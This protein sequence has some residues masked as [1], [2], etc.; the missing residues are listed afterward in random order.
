MVAGVA[1]GM[2]TITASADG[3]SGSATITVLDGGIVSSNGGT[4]NVQS[5]AVQIEVPPDALTA[6]TNLSVAVSNAFGSDPRVVPNSAFDFGPPGTNFAK[7]VLL[8]IRYD[9][10]TLPAGTE[11][12]ALELHIHASSGWE[13]VPQSVV[14]LAARTVNASVSHFST[15]AILTPD[16][17]AGISIG[18]AS[19]LT[20][21]ETEQLTATVTVGNGRVVTNR[22]LT[23]ASSDPTVASISQTGNV[24][25]L[26]PGSTTISAA[27]G[28]KTSS[29]MITVNAVPV[30]TV[31]VNPPSANIFV[32]GTL[33]LA[34]TIKDANGNTL[35][36]RAIAWSSSNSAIATV[37]AAS[38]FV[39]GVS[40]G[41]PVTITATSEGKSGASSIT[42]NR[43]PVAM[44]IVDPISA[45]IPVGGTRQL[46]A[47][48]RDAAGNV[49]T[50]R[51]VGWM[52]NNPAVATVDAATGLVTAVTAGGPVTI[53]ATSEGKSGTSA[54]TVTAVTLAVS[55]FITSG[56][57]APV[58]LTQPLNDGRIFVVEQAGRIRVV[59]N[60]LLQA[61]AFLDITSIVNYGGELG[62]LSVAFHPQYAANHFFY[63]Y[64]T[65]SNGEIRIERFTATA[66][67][68]VAD[69]T[70]RKLIFTTPHASFLNHNGGLVSFGPDGMLYAAFG[71]G[72]SGG[73]PL[74]NGQN[75][76]AYLGGMI[77][78]DVD[79]GD[80]YS[81]PA[82]NPFVG[83]ANRK[84][85]LWAKGLRN[86]WRYAF[87][88]PTGLLIIADVGQNLHEEVDAVAS[89]QG[90]LNYGWNI[91]EG[92][93]CFQATS[94]NQTGLQ[95][96]IL[97]YGHVGGVCSITGGYVYRGSA[98]PAIQGHYFYSDY[99]AG[100]L[101]SLRY[102]AGVAVDQK[103]WGVTLPNGQVTSFGQ[104][105][106]G[107]LY[108]MSAN[109]I[110]KLVPGP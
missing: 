10:A 55:P 78:I 15:Y 89:T 76:D 27:A 61:T 56:L 16:A 31:T 101:H 100:W 60:G 1:P 98:I 36:G 43:V 52:S 58:F 11:E 17:V 18:G 106:A 93:S 68:S 109:S 77:R 74:G 88:P 4:L 57:S 99:C 23:W 7:P 47:T 105:V 95:L 53:T 42:V 32:G 45:S 91:M 50:G 104:D 38:G 67:P 97:D 80:P 28:G 39:T 110:Y 75:F 96:P 73:D 82:N 54:I 14:D 84:P 87:D 63:V 102:Q 8:K 86:P 90:G 62:L 3:K 65:G 19:S 108:I 49:L 48:L 44:V 5:G 9:P 2:T 22:A 20:A 94:C 30:A 35:L 69:P 70:S 34:A 107:E 83:Q 41:G 72:G 26:K 79:N 92:L 66:D 81:V 25:A 46:T 59:Q 85:E 51:A 37:D 40:A 103:D 21:G 24:A 64:F 29:V 6:N 71:D 33:Q 12:T 13:V